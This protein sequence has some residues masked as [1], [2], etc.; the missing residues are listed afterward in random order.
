MHEIKIY[1][2][3]RGIYVDLSQTPDPVFAEKMV[4]D[5]FAIEPLEGSM[6]AP[7]TGVVKDIHHAKHAFTISN[8]DIDVL[9]HTGIDTVLL[10]GNGFNPI[11]KIGDKVKAGDKLM[12]FDIQAISGQVKSLCTPC[13]I[14]DID[15]KNLELIFTN[16]FNKIDETT[17]IATITTKNQTNKNTV[18]EN[19]TLVLE[20]EWITIKNLHGI[21]ARP[22]A[23]IN[24]IARQYAGDVIILKAD[25]EANAKSLISLMSISIQ[26][27][28]T[29]KIIVRDKHATEII[30]K[31]SDLIQSFF[32]ETSVEEQ[33]E[34]DE[35]KVEGHNYFG[36]IASPGIA[37]GKAVLNNQNNLFEFNEKASDIDNEY[38]QAQKLFAN[39][40][41]ELEQLINQTKSVVEQTIL[42]SHLMILSDPEITTPTYNLIKTGFS[43]GYAVNKV[44][45]EACQI[46]AGTKSTLLAER[47][48]D[49]K[50]VKNRL[51][52]KIYPNIKSSHQNNNEDIILIADDF[53]PSQVINLANNV[54]GLISVHGATTSH[55]AILA[56]SK[57]IPLLVAVSDNI[58]KNNYQEIIINNNICNTK[59]NSEEIAETKVKLAQN[60]QK[61]N[62]ALQSAKHQAKTIDDIVVNCYANI[63]KANEVSN[64]LANG[65]DGV[66]LMRSEFLFL[67][68]NEAPNETQQLSEYQAISNNLGELALTIRTLDIGG[69]KQVHYLQQDS[70]QNPMLGVRGIRLCLNNVE[71]FKT[72][73]SA[74][75]K[76]KNKKLKIMLPMITYLEEYRQAKKLITSLQ[77]QINDTTPIELG[78]MV[79][80][81]AVIFNIDNFAKEVDFMSIGSND[82]SQYILAIDREHTTLGKKVDHLHPSVLNAIA[83]TAKSA[84]THNKPI[85]VCGLMASEIMAIPILIG[86]GIT[87]LSMSINS[88]AENKEFI[89]NLDTRK[90]QAIAKE[91]LSLSTAQEVRKL[92]Q[93]SFNI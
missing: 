58:L 20:S 85:S 12:D 81:P 66:G 30:Q 37:I 32:D 40:S 9:I 59:P 21:H 52:Q 7:I 15:E 46:L 60:Q 57:N 77:Q 70:E 19:N 84:N 8:D 86:L 67:D 79:E 88:I 50:D 91:C 16:S 18:A 23:Q 82:L 74:L 14:A 80:V 10:K 47:Q 31:L 36:T 45:T 55:V 78:I 44:I 49:L 63:G 11:V 5:G 51:L 53:T 71:L 38:L 75:L 69:D 39:V 33:L 89:R 2:P 29:I 64:A 87:N 43:I 35:I 34:N 72:Q 61:L 92:I 17:H 54:K 65:A 76:T 22:A 1:S 56:R 48:S 26:Y 28:D 25:K 83:I 24:T 62:S 90:C 68:S 27:G 93:Q 6:F 4:G 41:S 13:I 3:I 73:L 42:K